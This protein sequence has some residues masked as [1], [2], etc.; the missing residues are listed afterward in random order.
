MRAIPE[1]RSKKYIKK[2]K[3]G[4]RVKI[5]MS[6]TAKRSSKNLTKD[7]VLVEIG[8]GIKGY[9]PLNLLVS[10]RPRRRTSYNTIKK[11]NFILSYLEGDEK[12]LE[13]NSVYMN[14]NPNLKEEREGLKTKTYYRSRSGNR[15]SRIRPVKMKITAKPY[16]YMRNSP[17]KYSGKVGKVYYGEIVEVLGY[18]SKKEYIDGKYKPWAKINSQGVTGWSYSGYLEKL[19]VKRDEEN[20]LDLKSGDSRYVKTALL[21]VRDEPSNEG[22]VITS[23]QHQKKVKIV[24]VGDEIETIQRVRSKWVE[25]EYEDYTGWVFGGFLSKDKNAYVPEDKIDKQ[26]VW[27]VDGY[28][29]ISSKYGYRWNPTSRRKERKFHKGIDI[30]APRGTLIK[31]AASGYVIKQKYSGGYGRVIMLEHTDGNRSVYAHMSSYIAKQGA[32]VRSGQNIGRVGTSGR[33]TGNHLHF[34]IR[35]GEGHVNPNKYVHP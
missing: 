8:G 25:V 26:Y 15:Y 6:L 19:T 2:V 4:W 20:P 21:R 24:D 9:I 7:W 1:D 30:P 32:R 3:R 28:R 22:C 31:A 34:E 5:L 17:N 33:S 27:P 14:A 13:S 23:I 12:Y 16:L 10:N 35:S 29:R 18:S 11:E